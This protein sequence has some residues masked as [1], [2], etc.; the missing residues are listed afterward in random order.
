MHIP[1]GRQWIEIVTDKLI[2][3]PGSLRRRSKWCLSVE[4]PEKRSLQVQD[5]FL[6]ITAPYRPLVFC[7]VFV[8]C[9]AQ[10]SDLWAHQ[11]MGFIC[12]LEDGVQRGRLLSVSHT[13]DQADCFKPAMEE[14]SWWIVL[15]GQPN[16]VLTCRLAAV[17]FVTFR[18][19][20]EPEPKP[21]D[22]GL[23]RLNHRTQTWM[24]VQV[25]WFSRTWTL[26][27]TAICIMFGTISI[28]FV[29]NNKMDLVE[30]QWKRTCNNL[31]TTHCMTQSWETQK[32]SS[33]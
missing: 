14:R 16:A 29:C 9:T 11:R 30:F 15:N 5:A 20:F 33:Y 17:R 13:G 25:Q 26:Y 6:L 10:Y 8:S 3:V 2:R 22:Q 27:F 31:F 19:M 18:T 24:E 1:E 12:Y 7:F 23:V 32:K 28:F 21:N 4:T